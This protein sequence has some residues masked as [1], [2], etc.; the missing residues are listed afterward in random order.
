MK[1]KDYLFKI[2][3]I[4][5][6]IIC[7]FENNTDLEEFLVSK[8]LIKKAF[9][10]AKEDIKKL[11]KNKSKTVSESEINKIVLKIISEILIDI[12]GRYQ[13]S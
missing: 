6:N 9:V 4:S 5:N 12:F 11:I 3:L 8:E 7:E 13:S 1:K 2:L 10:K